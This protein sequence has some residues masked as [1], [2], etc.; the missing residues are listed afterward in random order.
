MGE[1]ENGFFFLGCL[2]QSGWS[3]LDDDL[4]IG[5]GSEVG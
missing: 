1:H 5:C 3:E 2:I 4:L